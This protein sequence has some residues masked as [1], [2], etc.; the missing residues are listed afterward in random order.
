MS[1]EIRATRSR[2]A[3]FAATGLLVMMA[4][5]GVAWGHAEKTLIYGFD[6]VWPAAVRF[7]RVDEGLT[8]TEK[9]ADAGYVLFELRED[10][11]TFPGALELVRTADRGR[12]AIHLVLRIEDR[13]EYV[14]Q[15]I[16]DRLET[17]LLRELGDPPPPVKPPPRET[18]KDAP[19]DPPP[20]DPPVGP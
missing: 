8:I 11:K 2:A 17:K 12:D 3:T 5:V 13:P 15:G 14:E 4:L 16:L 1:T 7:L 19:K 6:R 9:D 18:P 10:G 20:A